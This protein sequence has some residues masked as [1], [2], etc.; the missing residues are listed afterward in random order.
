MDLFRLEVQAA[1]S[2]Q[3]LGVVRVARP[4]GY[5][6]VTL[7]ALVSAA[8]LIGFSTWGEINRKTKV[9]GLLVPVGG[10]LNISAPQS[11]IIAEKPALEGRV[12][13]SGEVMMVLNTE[14]Q[15]ALGT[16]V[17]QTRALAAEQIELRK[18]S[19]NTQ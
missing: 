16:V 6:L 15:S 5:T 8:L 13:N 19:L 2:A 12:V 11:G 1:Q 9:T 7:W 3:W 17:G 14:R 4:L 10:S 18:Q